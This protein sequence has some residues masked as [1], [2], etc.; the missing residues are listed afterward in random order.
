MNDLIL[1]A[2]LYEQEQLEKGLGQMAVNALDY[3]TGSEGDLSAGGQSRNPLPLGKNPEAPGNQRIR[4]GGAVRNTLGA[5][6]DAG[7]AM[8]NRQL[9]TAS[10]RAAAQRQR[11]GLSAD[12]QSGLV[13]QQNAALEQQ[14]VDSQLAGQNAAQTKLMRNAPGLASDQAKDTMGNIQGGQDPLVESQTGAATGGSAT[15]FMG[16]FASGVGNLIGQGMNAYNAQRANQSNV[17]AGSAG[18][19]IPQ[20]SPPQASTTGTP[21]NPEEMSNEEY[22]V[23]GMNPAQNPPAQ[24]PPAQN[25]QP[26]NLGEEAKRAFGNTAIA[27]S[28]TALA[29]AKGKANT[30]GGFATNPYLGLL[31]GGMSNVLGAGY[32]AWQR[33]KGR[34]EVANVQNRQQRLMANDPSAIQASEDI[35]DHYYGIHKARLEIT[36]RRSTEVVRLAYR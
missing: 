27:D 1:K 17:G 29:E 15:N 34:Q 20:A 26:Y 21:T 9:P 32:N 7:T 14:K 13:E 31:T 2:R 19:G 28:Q 8:A 33:G 6:R 3:V 4:T 23:A 11:T 22:L 12:E 25:Q 18:Q 16:Q 35:L 30:K 10:N 36:D 24:N 5:M